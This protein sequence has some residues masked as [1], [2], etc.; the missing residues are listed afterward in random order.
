M[1]DRP[2]TLLFS[3]FRPTTSTLSCVYMYPFLS[4]SPPRPGYV[5]EHKKVDDRP[6]IIG[7]KGGAGADL[8]S[9]AMAHARGD[10]DDSV[11]CMRDEGIFWNLWGISGQP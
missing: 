8:E 10:L 3:M 9:G 11:G 4:P 2:S 7:P 6:S 5:V 1:D